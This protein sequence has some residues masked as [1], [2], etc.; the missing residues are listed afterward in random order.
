MDKREVFLESNNFH[1]RNLNLNDLLYS[2]WYSWFNDPQLCNYNK[3]H[4]WPNTLEK[5]KR[6]LVQDDARLQL[7]IVHK[8]LQENLLGVI[9]LEQIDLIHR[10]ANLGIMFEKS[11]SEK[12]P[13]LFYES[14]QII[15]S[16]GFNQLGL[17]KI[18]SGSAVPNHSLT[19]Q[20]LF[21]F[22]VE[23]NLKR[24]I[25]KSGKFLDV[26]LLALFR[27]RYSLDER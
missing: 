24:E 27:E 11:S 18:R 15:L 23:G 3:H 10:N 16:H 1:Y 17:L 26:S 22:E 14:V 20:R 5:Q 7:G 21:N 9:S 6:Y 2:N 8:N 4:Y 19:M 13:T 25:F 12:Y